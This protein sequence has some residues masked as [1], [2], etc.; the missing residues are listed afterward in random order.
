MAFLIDTNQRGVLAEPAKPLR[1]ADCPE[2]SR[3]ID[4]GASQAAAGRARSGVSTERE[5]SPLLSGL[6]LRLLP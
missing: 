5:L 3:E 4:K 2:E 6:K 1:P